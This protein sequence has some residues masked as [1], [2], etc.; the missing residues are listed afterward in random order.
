MVRRTDCLILQ[1]QNT[2]KQKHKTKINLFIQVKR[3][4]NIFLLIIIILRA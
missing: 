4:L 2:K 3:T 1:S